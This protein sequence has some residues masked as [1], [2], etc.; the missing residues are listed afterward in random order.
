MDSTTNSIITIIVVI[1][2]I[3]VLVWLIMAFANRQPSQ[4]GAENMPQQGTEQ[5]QQNQGGQQQSVSIKNNAFDPQNLTISKGLTVTWTNNDTQDHS[6]KS[7]TF[8][9]NTLTPGSTYQHTFDATGTYDY[10]CG[11]HPSMRGQII[12]Q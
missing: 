3:L 1:I 10:T 5:Q 8:N 2:I 7:E 12:V 11:I 6:V 4:Q 9:S